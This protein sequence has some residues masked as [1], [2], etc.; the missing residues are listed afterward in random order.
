M[1]M[2][3]GLRKAMLTA[4]V[5]ASIGWFGAVVAFLALALTGTMSQDPQVVR[6]VYLVLGVTTWWAIVPLALLAVVTGVVSSLFTKWGLFRYYW[7]LVKLVLTA[8]A[9]FGLLEHATLVNRLAGVAARTAVLGSNFAGAQ[10]SL[11]TDAAGGLVV[12]LLLT[13]LSVYKPRGLTPYGQRKQDEQRQGDAASHDQGQESEPEDA[14]T[15]VQVT[16]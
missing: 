6:A 12:L 2:P 8:G 3:Q 1:I 14:S 4:H 9:T 13:V 16:R 5:I 11:V 10:Q 7:V 15:P